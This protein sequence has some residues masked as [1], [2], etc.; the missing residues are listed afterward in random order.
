MAGAVLE[1]IVFNCIKGFGNPRYRGYSSIVSL[2]FLAVIRVLLVIAFHFSRQLA[3]HIYIVLAFE[4]LFLGSSMTI[5]SIAPQHAVPM[6]FAFNFCRIFVTMFQFVIDWFLYSKPL[7]MMQIQA[8]LGAVLSILGLVL[9]IYYVNGEC[10]VGPQ[11]AKPVEDNPDAKKQEVVEMA[12]LSETFQKGL[13][14]LLIFPAGA[15][16]KDFLYPGVL[17]YAILQRD[18][19]HIIN[20]LA[21]IL[22][23]IGSF[24]L[25]IFEQI[26]IYNEWNHYYDGYWA[27]TIPVTI[28]S[29]YTMMAIHTRIP[30]ATKIRNS[31][32]IVMTMTLILMIYYSFT[33]PLSFTGVSKVVHKGFLPRKGDPSISTIH[34]NLVFVYRFVFSKISVGYNN[35]RVSLGYHLP[36]FRPN[37]RMSKHNLAWYFIRNTFR[38]AWRDTGRDLKMDIRDFL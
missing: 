7:V 34:T 28:I 33:F 35:T 10:M 27:M 6:M 18:K 14:P 13:S 24:V 36:K 30:A 29:V 11:A 20:K 2:G 17:P 25:F 9:W 32:P 16:F 15:I 3:Y 31:K 21:T 5:I 26:G 12:S 23:G 19:C 4:A 22:Y 38:T 1:Y 37:H 8:W